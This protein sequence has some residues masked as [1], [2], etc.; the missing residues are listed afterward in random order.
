M[1]ILIWKTSQSVQQ[2]AQ[3]RQIMVT[4]VTQI[5]CGWWKPPDAG[6][7]DSEMLRGVEAYGMQ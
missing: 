6:I 3:K 5:C 7:G 2:V 4:E 1:V